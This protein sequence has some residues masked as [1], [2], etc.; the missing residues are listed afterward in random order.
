M[1]AG[2]DVCVDGDIGVAG[3]LGRQWGVRSPLPV[4]MGLPACAWSGAR[5]CPWLLTH[6]AAE[7]PWKASTPLPALPPAR[8]GLAGHLVSLDE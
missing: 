8:C 5:L 2:M 6:S 3:W 4:G 7:H 1:C